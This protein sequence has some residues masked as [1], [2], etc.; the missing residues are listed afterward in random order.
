[1]RISAEKINW[2]VALGELSLIV[3]GILMA[4]AIDSYVERR[5]D[6]AI[7][8][9]YLADMVVE[10][11]TDA[12]HLAQ[13]HN[14]IGGLI[15][16]ASHLLRVIETGEPHDDPGS[17]LVGAIIGEGLTR[18]AAVWEELQVTGAL[19]LIPE[20]SARTAIVTHYLRRANQFKTIDENFIPAVRDLRAL[21]WDI[22]PID[23]FAQYFQSAQSG[24][25]AATVVTRLQDRED[26]AYLLKRV[27][28]T[29]TVARL[30]LKSAAASTAALL[31]ELGLP[32]ESVI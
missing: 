29:G 23:S 1:M 11:Q 32:S 24:V 21:A 30:Q 26:A 13:S 4:L 17:L 9:Q 28:V 7:A 10:L 14:R 15:D 8:D 25:P 2:S 31:T 22:L 6:Q 18:Q 12:E 5:E 27:I 16:A 20:Q 3:V 19:R